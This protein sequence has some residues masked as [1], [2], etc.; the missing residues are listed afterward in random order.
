MEGVGQSGLASK[1]NEKTPL[2]RTLQSSRHSPPPS[3]PPPPPT[4]QHSF[5]E[6]VEFSHLV[7]RETDVTHRKTSP[8]VAQGNSDVEGGGASEEHKTEVEL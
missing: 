7:A 2:L 8:T 4:G 5:A 3:P 6:T 1:S